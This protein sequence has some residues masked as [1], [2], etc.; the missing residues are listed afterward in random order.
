MKTTHEEIWRAILDGY[1]AISNLG[2]VKRIKAGQNTFPGRILKPGINSRGYPTFVSHIN[3]IAK[4]LTVHSFVA[5]EFIGPR[6][7]GHTINHKNGM[8]FDNR[9][10]NLE[11]VTQKENVQHAIRIGLK[12][13]I[14]ENNCKAKLTWDNV[15]K[16][17]AVSHL[18]SRVK[19]AKR[20]NVS[21]SSISQ[22]I[23]NRTWVATP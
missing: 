19:L 12:N 20:F 5:S 1:Y 11:Y 13:Q 23:H 17:R 4:S 18:F 15:E 16:I 3:S 22:V 14:G 7:K 21:A 6:P 9:A 10:E 2:G 8:K